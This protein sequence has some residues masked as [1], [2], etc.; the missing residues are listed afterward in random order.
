VN[1]S[2]YIKTTLVLVMIFFSVST[3]ANCL[4]NTEYERIYCEIVEQGE[5]KSLPRFEDFKRND[6]MVQKL[7]LKRPAEKLK[8]KLPASSKTRITKASDKRPVPEKSAQFKLA[9]KPIKKLQQSTPDQVT[10][11][12]LSQ[13]SIAKN[14]ISCGHRRFYLKKNEPNSRLAKGVLDEQYKMGLPSYKGD[15]EDGREIQFYLSDVYG[16]YI[17]KMVDIGL[18][19]STMSYARFFHTF[20]DLQAKNVDFSERFETMYSFLKKDKK[21]MMVKLEPSAERPNSI[22][23]CDDISKQVIVCD[24]GVVNWVYVN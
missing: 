21:T 3:V 17:Q 5:G 6:V 20:N 16:L 2:M 19:A 24:I 18:G 7:L 10:N 9:G 4:S 13:C 14:V 11:V 23:Q 15:A 8:I 22:S 1:F 12:S